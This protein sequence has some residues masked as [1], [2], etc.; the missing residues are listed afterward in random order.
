MLR[1]FMALFLAEAQRLQTTFSVASLKFSKNG[2]QLPFGKL[3]RAYCR[4]AD[5]LFFSP[6]LQT[7]KMLASTK[8]ALLVEAGRLQ[9]T[10]FQN[11]VLK[12][13]KN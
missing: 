6:L 5:L 10:C 4:F 11:F 2:Q 9:T 1:N 7:T 3:N 13:T 8:I 12:N